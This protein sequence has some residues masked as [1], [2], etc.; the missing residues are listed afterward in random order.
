MPIA[1]S[2]RSRSRQPC[3]S[4]APK[5]ECR[6]NLCP[7]LWRPRYRPRAGWVLPAA[8][9]AWQRATRTI[10]GLVCRP[11][12]LAPAPR[13]APQTGATY[14]R[15]LALPHRPQSPGAFPSRGL[16][17]DLESCLEMPAC[18][19]A[20]HLRRVTTCCPPLVHN[21]GVVNKIQPP[22]ICTRDLNRAAVPE[23]DA[24]GPNVSCEACCRERPRPGGWG[25]STALGAPELT[26]GP[27]SASAHA[28][29]AL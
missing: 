8:S 19:L 12:L 4:N 14:T 28:S 16:S 23:R 25:R 5:I 11:G 15:A 9:A 20:L 10:V 29:R 24:R 13:R 27:R 2:D 7:S 1:L 17:Q 3:C 22:C 26:E 18:D 21:V 6:C